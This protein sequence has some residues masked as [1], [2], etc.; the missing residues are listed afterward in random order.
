MKY[1]LHSLQINN[2][3]LNYQETLCG[4]GYHR[5]RCRR[6]FE[7]IN[8]AGGMWGRSEGQSINGNHKNVGIF[9][10]PFVNVTLLQPIYLVVGKPLSSS[11]LQTSLIDGPSE[12]AKQARRKQD[13][14]IKQEVEE[15][16]GV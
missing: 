4:G 5:S 8:F 13:G 11:S 10:T 3:N 1:F 14:M 9:L 16:E 2:E 12:E 7:K 15:E 6:E